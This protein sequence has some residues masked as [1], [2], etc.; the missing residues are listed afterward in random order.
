MIFKISRK[1]LETGDGEDYLLFHCI[2]DT[3]SS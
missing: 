1:V 3:I 2:Y